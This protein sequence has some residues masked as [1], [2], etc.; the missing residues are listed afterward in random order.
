MDQTLTFAAIEKRK[1]KKEKLMK[2][3]SKTVLITFHYAKTY[4]L[5]TDNRSLAYSSS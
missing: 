2:N 4:D 1:T 3:N 5:R